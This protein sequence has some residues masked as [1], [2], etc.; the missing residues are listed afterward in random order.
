VAN[1][2]SFPNKLP[3]LHQASLQRGGQAPVPT[4]YRTGEVRLPEEAG[5][6]ASK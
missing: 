4:I 3:D 2:P 6:N 5:Y 1:V